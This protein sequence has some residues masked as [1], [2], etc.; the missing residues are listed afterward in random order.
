MTAFLAGSFS[1]VASTL[2]FQPLDLLKTRL[3]TT[4]GKE[5]GGLTRALA[6]VVTRHGVAGL[7]RGLAPSLA[8]TVPGVGLYFSAAHSLRAS[9]APDP[10]PATSLLVGAAARSLAVT[11][12]IPVTVVKLRCE[13][14]EAAGTRASD[15]WRAEGVR[16]LTRGLLPTI[17]RDAPF[18]G[19]YMML[20]D[21]IKTAGE[22][23]V[24]F[25]T[26]WTEPN[27]QS[28]TATTAPW[29]TACWRA[30]RPPSSP[31]Q[32]TWSRR[33]CRPPGRGPC[34]PPRPPRRCWRPRGPGDCSAASRRGWCGGR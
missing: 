19:I 25:V 26:H 17:L 23:G 13:A 12:T 11:A 16:G 2:L 28:G 21:T 34:P 33:S 5:A 20:Y 18:S 32:R 15:I 29:V 31:S 1:G 6:S 22:C 4:G 27:T 30:A 3:Q 7:W 24:K 8:R 14:A 10:S 9:L